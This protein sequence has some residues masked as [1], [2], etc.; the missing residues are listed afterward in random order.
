M[1]P[2]PTLAT[3]LLGLASLGGCSQEADQIQPTS[4]STSTQQNYTGDTGGATQNGNGAYTQKYV[5]NVCISNGLTGISNSSG[6]VEMA[7][8]KW[9]ITPSGIATAVWVGTIPA[10]ATLPDKQPFIA[11]YEEYGNQYTCT[12]TFDTSTNTFKLVIS[13]K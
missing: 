13:N 4:A 2:A 5:R 9:M 7:Q 8:T 6:C 1:K 12:T 10:D 11:P 3:L